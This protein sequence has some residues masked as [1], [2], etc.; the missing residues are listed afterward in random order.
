MERKCFV[1]LILLDCLVIL[2]CNL[3]S[4]KLLEIVGKLIESGSEKAIEDSLRH[5]F[6]LHVNHRLIA[7]L[8]A[9]QKYG[10]KKLKS[11]NLV[12]FLSQEFK[13]TPELFKEFSFQV[14]NKELL[15]QK[16]E[17]FDNLIEQQ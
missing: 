9:A 16:K 17:Y 8:F 12:S 7:E 4:K 6:E 11:V 10:Y 5:F 2:R 1:F 15:R 13:Q 14:T 3:K